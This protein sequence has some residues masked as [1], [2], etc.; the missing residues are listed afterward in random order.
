M[1]D[2]EEDEGSKF[3]YDAAKNAY[4]QKLMNIKSGVMLEV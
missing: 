1:G 3:D 2:K 4:A